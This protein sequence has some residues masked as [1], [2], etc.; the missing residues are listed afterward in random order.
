[1]CDFS[2]GGGRGFKVRQLIVLVVLGDSFG[3]RAPSLWQF[4]LFI[5]VL[6]FGSPLFLFQ[7]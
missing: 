5:L 2:F 6:G 3:T 7:L 4:V 1:M